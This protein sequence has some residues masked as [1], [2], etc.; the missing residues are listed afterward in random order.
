[1][2]AISGCGKVIKVIERRSAGRWRR[3]K[4]SQ[5]KSGQPCLRKHGGKEGFLIEDFILSGDVGGTVSLRF[6]HY[7]GFSYADMLRDITKY[8]TSIS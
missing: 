7:G 8:I 5:E 1:M 2:I 6:R 4:I 3:S